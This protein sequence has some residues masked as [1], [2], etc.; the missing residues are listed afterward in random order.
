VGGLKLSIGSIEPVTHKTVHSSR[1]PQNVNKNLLKNNKKAKG[2]FAA[3]NFTTE[4]FSRC[5]FPRWL[6]V[7]S[8][9]L[10]MMFLQEHLENRP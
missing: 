7:K 2:D 4:S 3:K 6:Y 1:W 5:P 8:V 10:E 9:A